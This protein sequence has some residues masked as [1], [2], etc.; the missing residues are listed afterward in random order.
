MVNGSR[1]WNCEFVNREWRNVNRMRPIGSYESGGPTEYWNARVKNHQLIHGQVPQDALALRRSRIP[2]IDTAAAEPVDH[3]RRRAA[4]AAQSRYSE[5]RAV[6]HHFPRA[7]D[8]RDGLESR[9]SAAS[10]F[11][12]G[13]RT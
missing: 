5:L 12:C 3:R 11:R 7:P 6:G 9:C 8:V 10:C 13:R 1:L 2:I 4:R